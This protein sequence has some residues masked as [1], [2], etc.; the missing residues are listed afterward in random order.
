MQQLG[1]A[2]DGAAERHAD[3]LVA[4]AHPEQRGFGR[5]AGLHEG[6][7]G[8]RAFRGAGPGGE[9]D[10]V[11]RGGGV[12]DGGVGGQAVVVVAPD[13]RVHPELAQVLDQVEHEAVVVVDDREPASAQVTAAISA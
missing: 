6:D 2:V 8:A 5:R 4:Q 11:E 13:L 9:Q 7:R 1:C 12:G 10:A 3:G